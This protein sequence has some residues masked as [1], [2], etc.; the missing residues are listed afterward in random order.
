MFFYK[1]RADYYRY[2][3]EIK[4][5]SE[6]KE[7]ALS[8]YKAANDISVNELKPTDPMRLGLALNFSVFYYEI[9]N[10]PDRACRLAKAAFDEAIGEVDRLTDS[11]Y[12][13]TVIIMQL[14]RNN[15]CLWCVDDDRQ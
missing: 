5:D 15:L 14:I 6:D 1:L 10:S 13:D 3:C 2:L 12:K 8:A 9:L 7:N 11:N 4:G